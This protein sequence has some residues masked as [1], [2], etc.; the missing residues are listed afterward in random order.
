MKHFRGIIVPLTTPYDKNGNI[1][2]DELQNHL[3]IILDAGV[4][5]ILIPSGTGEFANLSIEKRI[6]LVKTAA[7]VIRG[8]VPLVAMISD[9]STEVVLDIARRMK[10]A[11]ASEAMMTPPYFS[12]INQRSIYEFFNKVADECGLPLWIYHQPGETKLTVEP[13]TV[14]KLAE[15]PNIVGMKIAPGYD[16]FYFCRIRQLMRHN[17][18]FSLLNGEDFDLFPSLMI[19]GDGGV[20]SLANIIPKQFVELFDLC[21]EGK[22]DE[23][24]GIHDLI[25]DCYDLAVMVDTGAYQSAVK[26][27]LM[28]QG[29]YSTNVVSGPFLT[30]EHE[31]QKVVLEK[32]KKCGIIKEL[33][34]LI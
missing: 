16:F 3:R 33:A 7:S 2:P 18:S 9:C 24:K 8:R 25:M 5:G 26:T 28:A 11:G 15:N 23:A 31:E 10:D 12:T 30:I 19:G 20:A 4:H 27:V 29:I 22:Y 21:Q 34:P 32:A 14:V 17:D 6:F 13:E 1:L